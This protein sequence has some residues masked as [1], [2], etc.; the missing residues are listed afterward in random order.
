MTRVGSLL[1]LV[2]ACLLQAQDLS[3]SPNHL[4]GTT[5]LVAGG[6]NGTQ[7]AL[8]TAEVYTQGTRRFTA[9]GSMHQSR[10]GQAAEVSVNPNNGDT[11]ILVAGGLGQNKI[12]VASA[13]LYDAN[14]GTFSFTGSMTTPRVGHT[15]GAVDNHAIPLIHVAGGQNAAFT[16]L[17]SAELYNPT[18]GKFTPTG[19]MHQP[20]AYHTASHLLTQKTLIAGGQYNSTILASAELYDPNTGTFALTGKMSIPRVHH[21]AT[22]LAD[23]RVLIAGGGSLVGNCIGCSVASAEIYDPN[24]GVFTPVGNMHFARRGHVAV[25]IQSNTICGTPYDY[26]VLVAGGVDDALPNPF[27]ASAEIF[28]LNTL[29]FSPAPNMTVPR[30][31]AAAERL[32]NGTV[33]ITGGFTSASTVTNKAEIYN[34][35]T[36]L[37]VATG[38]MTA[39]RAEHTANGF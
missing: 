16:T 24:S 26:C 32:F 18:T 13:E 28:N 12:P 39:A 20:R 37:F 2:F 31:N 27:L 9:T 11:T 10:A 3:N 25:Q 5:V 8:S 33:L 7:P 6:T 34:P 29:T 4:A 17:S 38:S 1:L 21:T 30:F 15:A 22:F 36:G 14:T 19:S 23:G 35:S